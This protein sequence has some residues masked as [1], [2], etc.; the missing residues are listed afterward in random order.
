MNGYDITVPD[1]KGEEHDS[2]H[3]RNYYTKHPALPLELEPVV[4]NDKIY[5]FFYNF[6]Y[7]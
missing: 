3:Q 5:I 2:E 7:K 4:Y 6:I 1:H